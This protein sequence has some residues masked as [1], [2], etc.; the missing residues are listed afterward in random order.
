MQKILTSKDNYKELSDFLEDKEKIL[1]VCDGSINFLEINNYFNSS[2]KQI[3]RFS[4][5]EPNP[6]YS[7][8]V[9]GVKS[10]QNFAPDAIIAVGGGSAMDVAKCIKLYAKNNPGTDLTEQEPEDAA[11]PLLA[12]PTTAGTGAESTHFAVV[13]KNGSK[14]SVTDMRMVPEFV[15]MDPTVLNTLPQYQK[16]STVAD[17]LCHS[18][19]SF[20]SVNSTDES[21]EYA[22]QAINFLSQNIDAYLDGDNS[23]NA[24]MLE[25]ANLAGRAINISETTAGHA[26]CYKLTSHYGIAHGHAA[27]LCVRVLFP[28]MLENTDKC[29]DARGE[30]YLKGTFGELARA[31]GED[32]PQAAAEKFNGIFEKLDLEIPQAKE[33][34]FAMLAGSVNPGRLKNNPVGI[35]TATAE[36]LYRKILRETNR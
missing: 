18:V 5:F 30:E 3:L 25:A 28:W 35:D 14:Y 21:K 33:E 29:T 22:R 34:D 10:F 9:S 11:T 23:V 12:L 31:M 2:D 1:L 36:K 15:L 7:S 13:Y 4:D 27:I 17:A 6:D 32:T 16:K 20:W 19:E 8:V 26:M 24:K